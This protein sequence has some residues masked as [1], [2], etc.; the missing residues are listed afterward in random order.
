[1]KPRNFLNIGLAFVLLSLIALIA[2]EPGEE[3]VASK[4]FI[5][6]LKPTDI[7][8]LVI[9]QAQY[10]RVVLTRT[11]DLWQI[12]E[13]YNNQANTLRIN[14]ILELSHAK[15]HAQYPATDINLKQL[16]LSTPDLTIT[17]NDTKLIFGTTDAIKGYR[18]IQVDNTVHLITDRF[19]H[20]IRGQ[21]SQ[22][23]SP[24]LLPKGT[25]ISKLVLPELTLQTNETGWSIS[26]DN[27][28]I[29][30]DQVQQFLDEWRFARAI[31]VSKMTANAD[32]GAT[33][34]K[35]SAIK[36]YS[37]ENNLILF[38]LTQT[39]DEIIL[40]RSD[41]GL[42]YHFTVEA[43]ERLLKP[44]ITNEDSPNLG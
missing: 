5:T 17:L 42:Q 34:S 39:E 38:D 18:Y 30:A 3:I 44:L 1:M 25:V 35:R 12:N 43:G 14:K 19:S 37:D 20:L 4:V 36:V 10:G 22:L 28:S 29:S 33:G 32:K 40:Q 8:K 16:N 41:T 6:Q 31:R 9:E 2:Y 24:A 26:P 13:P 23:L 7:H 27:K 11:N 21:A 15:S